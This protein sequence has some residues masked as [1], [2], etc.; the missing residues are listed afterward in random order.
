MTDMLK[1]KRQLR[2]ENRELLAEIAA[3]SKRERALTAL[4]QRHEEDVEG[5]RQQVTSATRAAV[6]SQGDTVRRLRQTI[7]DQNVTIRDLAERAVAAEA[8]VEARYEPDG[9]DWSIEQE[10]R[11]ARKQNAALEQRVAE[12]QAANES[13]ETWRKPVAS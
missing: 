6:A 10:L 9:P 2:R 8:L 7:D 4:C 12:L 11:V 5:L 3:L 1:T 13:L